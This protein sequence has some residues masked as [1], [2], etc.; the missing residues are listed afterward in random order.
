MSSMGIRRRGGKWEVRVACG[1]RRDGRPRTVSRMA[2]TEKEAEELRARLLAEM[3]RT[4]TMGDPVTLDTYFTAVFLPRVESTTTRANRDFYASA[5]RTHV[6]PALGALD[7][8]EITFPRVQSWVSGLPPASAPAY[9]RCLRAVLRAA[10]ADGILAEE[11]LR[12][13]LRLPR[14]VSAPRDVWCAEEAAECLA[15]VQGE[16]IEPLVLVMLGAGLSASEARARDWEDFGEGCALVSVTSA[17]TGRDGM[18]E[19]KCGRRWRTAPVLPQCAER[20]R[21]LM[22]AAGGSGPICVNRRGDRMGPG[23]TPRRWAA[24]FGEDGALEGM[25]RIDMN[26]LRATH[27]TLMQQAGV[28]DSLNAAIHGHS[29]KVAYSNYLRPVEGAV[30]AARAAGEALGASGAAAPNL[31]LV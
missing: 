20:L 8:S 2:E 21:E 13:R 16:D 27:E 6:S 31:R 23:T 19:P 28:S 9:V 10:W 14:R 15:R 7:V 5:Y 25:R 3:G 18:K 17:Y 11:P 1:Y 29:Q 30:G 4:P 22:D 12:Q 24:L 26:R